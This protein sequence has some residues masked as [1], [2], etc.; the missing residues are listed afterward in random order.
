MIKHYLV[1]FTD[2]IFH[3]VNDTQIK[4]RRDSQ[5]SAQWGNKYYLAEILDEGFRKDKLEKL[6]KQY[7]EG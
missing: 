6:K 4:N 5:V 2:G 1:R 7:A 3:I